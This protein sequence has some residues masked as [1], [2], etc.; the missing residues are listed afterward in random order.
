[1]SEKHLFIGGAADGKRMDL[2]GEYRDTYN[3]PLPPENKTAF[4]R[5]PPDGF[6]YSFETYRRESI[7]CDKREWCFYV[8]ATMSPEFAIDR[9]LAG[10]APE[11]REMEG[12][13]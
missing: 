1:M 2:C 13:R 3:V 6:T 11:R 12:G 4:C 9:L 7:R 5:L 8:L 10:Y